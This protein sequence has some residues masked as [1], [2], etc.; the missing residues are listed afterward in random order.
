MNFQEGYYSKIV[1]KLIINENKEDTLVK[2]YG[3][4]VIRIWDYLYTNTNR[5]GQC[6]FIID[7]LVEQCG[8]RPNNKK[9]KINDKFRN[10]LNSLQLQGLLEIVKQDK[11]ILVKMVDISDDY[12]QLYENEIIKIEEYRGKCN[13]NNLI[14]LYSLIKARMYKRKDKKDLQITFEAE[15]AY[16]SYAD[17]TENT[18][19]AKKSIS[20]YIEVLE[21]LNLIRHKNI[22]QKINKTT[23][24]KM[25][26]SNI[27]TLYKDG[28]EEEIEV[29]IKKYKYNNRDEYIFVEDNI[30]KQ[31]LG[32]LK[33]QIKKRIESGKAT[34]KDYKLLKEIDNK[35]LT[36]DKEG[37][38]KLLMIEVQ[39]LCKEILVINPE[40]KE[41]VRK[42]IL[43]NNID[44]IKFNYK[45]LL[46]IR[47]KLEEYLEAI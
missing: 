4:E 30:N 19:I 12:F 2:K 33:T 22:G 24:V 13:K 43:H 42:D 11:I 25:E 10:I 28:W 31:K 37:Y 38:K 23:G 36:D 45:Q 46:S 3:G 5:K 29:A 35:A 39:E 16:P 8:F 6:R 34:E 18:G 32:G 21:N 41:Y 1:K 7:D 47:L 17:I 44:L 40:S 14:A 15:I 27:Y 9:G 26:C 20:T